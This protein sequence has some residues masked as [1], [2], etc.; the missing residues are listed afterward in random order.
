[1]RYKKMGKTDLEVSV[2]GMGTWGLGGEFWGTVEDQIGI[3]AIHAAVDTGVTLID[4]APAYGMG[5]S[6]RVLGKALGGLQRDKVVISTKCGQ[7]RDISKPGLVWVKESKPEKIAQQLEESLINL[8]TD[9]IDIYFIHWPD[10]STPFEVTMEALEK[11]RKQGKIRYVGVSN[12]TPAQLEEIMAIGGV[13]VVQPHYSLLARDI[14][15]ELLPVVEKYGLGVFPYGSLGAGALTGK[16]KEAPAV[17]GNERRAAVPFY[18]FYKEPKWSRVL[19]FNAL[20]SKIADKHNVPLGHVAIN[21]SC[22]NPLVT[23]SL[24]GAK[25]KEQAISNAKA[26]EWLLSKEELAYIEESWH[27]C[28][29]D[30]M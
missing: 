23:S 6:E 13:D 1:M 21:W 28:F 20:L 12:F 2:I 16:Y 9:Y 18:N 25:S 14:E 29:D 17:D 22:Q 8:Q 10:P 27:K 7:Y 4:T 24:V 15:K 11:F 26:G 5:Q 19:Q 30:V 3:D